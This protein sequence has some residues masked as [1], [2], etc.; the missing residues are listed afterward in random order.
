MKNI[1][2]VVAHAAA[3]IACEGLMRTSEQINEIAKAMA[4]AQNEMKPALKDSL[5]PHFKSKYSN[6]E[7]V[8]DAIRIP[9]TSNGL[10]IWQDVTTEEKS[11]AITTRIVHI[12]GQ[13]VEFGPLSIPLNKMDAHGVGSASSYGKRYALCAAV[14]VVSGDEDDDGNLAI[15][16]PKE[17]TLSNADEVKA[18]GYADFCRRHRIGEDDSE[19]WHYI[20]FLIDRQGKPEISVTNAA[21]KNEAKFLET[22][23]KWKAQQMSQQAMQESEGAYK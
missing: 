20:K 2:L 3:L 6:I 17:I 21:V 4:V 12:S 13:W 22:F 23:E 9:M 15:V 8:W 5:N 11:V 19:V 16:K 18:N 1:N 14:G 10:T 7:S